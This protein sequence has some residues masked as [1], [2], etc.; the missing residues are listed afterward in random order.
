MNTG[1]KDKSILRKY[2]IFGSAKVA[3]FENVRFVIVK[4]FATM[5][6]IN[7]CYKL[8]VMFMIRIHSP[9]NFA[10]LP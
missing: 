8:P 1:N 9:F 2:F 5:I 4:Q 6:Y 3:F 7:T 10:S